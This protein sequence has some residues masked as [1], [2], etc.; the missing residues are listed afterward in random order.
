MV[1]GRADGQE[2]DDVRPPRVDAH[3]EAHGD[4]AVGPELVG[5]GLH[6]LHRELARLVERLRERHHLAGLR[7]LQVLRADRVDAAP[8]HEAER[9]E[10]GLLHEEELVDR[11]VA[12]EEALLPHRREALARVGGDL[13]ALGAELGARV[14]GLSHDGDGTVSRRGRQPSVAGL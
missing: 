14:D 11:E 5:L 9:L 1:H 8:H 13:E 10:A 4:D 7:L 12:R 2:L 3:V 6:A